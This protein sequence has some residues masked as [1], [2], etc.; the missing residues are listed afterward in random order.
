MKKISDQHSF[1]TLE[2]KE[3][4]AIDFLKRHEPQE[5]YFVGF[6]GGKDSIVTLKLCQ[7][8]GVKHQA[9]YSCTGIDE[10]TVVK[11]I[12]QN[13]PYVT[14]LKPK[15]DFW[16]GIKKYGP[17]LRMRRWCCD[18]LKK[19]PSKDILKMKVMGIRAEES[20][21]RASRPRISSFSKQNIFKPIFYWKEYDVWD[22][23][24]KYDLKY[25]DLY[26]N[27]ASR[28]GCVICPFIFGESEQKQKQLKIK[29]EKYKG[30]YEKFERCVKKWWESKKSYR[31]YEQSFE[32]YMD[33]Y[34]RGFPQKKL[35]IQNYHS[36]FYSI[37]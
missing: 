36:H 26:D 34:Y 1:F 24:E 6:S 25:P 21:R 30:M 14:W 35:N 20:V 16:H 13:Y 15:I 17:P 12:K 27:G 33:L 7:M 22:F 32:E 10:P 3:L 28:I 23:I 5:G 29:K 2:D 18:A 11:F 4:E 9:F 37:L 8:S 31:K 19:N